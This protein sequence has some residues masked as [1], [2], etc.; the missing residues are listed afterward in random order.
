MWVTLSPEEREQRRLTHKNH[1]DRR[2]ADRLTTV[3]P[4]HWG[5]GRG[6]G[7]LQSL[8]PKNEMLT[9]L[10]LAGEPACDLLAP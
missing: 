4:L 1:K 10:R 3:H 2:F 9:A 6:E 8:Q 5:E 7:N